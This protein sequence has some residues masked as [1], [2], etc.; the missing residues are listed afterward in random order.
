M[1]SKFSR[2]STR[3]Q[4]KP[5]VCIS[6]PPPTVPPP[7]V[8]TF[9]IVI[10]GQVTTPPGPPPKSFTYTGPLT[11]SGTNWQCNGVDNGGRAWIATFTIPLGPGSI[12]GALA[13]SIPGFPTTGTYLNA[14]YTN[15]IGTPYVCA[16]TPS[17]SPAAS[18]GCTITRNS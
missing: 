5:H 16:W 3:V 9:S 8:R 2:R 18:G 14:A 11:G 13:W 15:G 10:G 6:D 4:H 12:T 7:A 1:S 17:S